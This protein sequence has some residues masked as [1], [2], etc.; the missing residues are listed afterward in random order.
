VGVLLESPFPN[1]DAKQILLTIDF[2]SLVLDEILAAN[3][4]IGVVCKLFLFKT[5]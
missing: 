3:P 4:L 2:T 5:V 1:P